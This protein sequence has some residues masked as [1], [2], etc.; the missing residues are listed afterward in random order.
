MVFRLI[1]W[2]MFSMVRCRSFASLGVCVGVC[3]GGLLCCLVLWCCLVS[4][5]TG[6]LSVLNLIGIRLECFFSPFV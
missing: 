6:V 2:M 1:D 3:C 4:R 5:L